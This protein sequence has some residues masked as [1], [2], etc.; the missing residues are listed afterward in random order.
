MGATKPSFL[1]WGSGGA[2]LFPP[3][4][5]QPVTLARLA[6]FREVRHALG[7]YENSARQE[8]VMA[9]RKVG[10]KRHDNDNGVAV[11]KR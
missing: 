3:I 7:T 11:N 8:S 9:T 6:L 5:L 2:G 1:A 4:V 10:R